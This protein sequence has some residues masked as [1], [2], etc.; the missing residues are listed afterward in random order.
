MKQTIQTIHF[1]EASPVLR[2][3]QAKAL[4][5]SDGVTTETENGGMMGTRPDGIK[6][7]WHASLD[8]VPKGLFELLT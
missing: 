3:K 5:G 2:Q 4:L 7:M 6:V 1:I 8:S